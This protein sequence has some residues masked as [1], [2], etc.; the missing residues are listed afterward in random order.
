MISSRYPIYH[1]L[2]NHQ[3]THVKHTKYNVIALQ[4][5][6]LYTNCS[7][8]VGSHTS[9]RPN[10][11][12]LHSEHIPYLLMVYKFPV[13]TCQPC[14]IKCYCTPNIYTVYQQFRNHWFAHVKDTNTNGIPLRT[15]SLYT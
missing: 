8:I 2:R 3:F 10:K 6:T 9:K 15:Y 14:Q 12:L 11:I 4:T 5:Y 1:M 7:E 13:R